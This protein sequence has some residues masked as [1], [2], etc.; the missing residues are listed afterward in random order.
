MLHRDLVQHI[1]EKVSE[2]EKEYSGLAPL[3][4]L[5]YDLNLEY[6]LNEKEILNGLNELTNKNIV[7]KEYDNYYKRCY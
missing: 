5:L 1:I 2:L 3:N 7:K 6:N 4:I